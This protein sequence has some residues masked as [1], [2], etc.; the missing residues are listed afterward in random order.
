MLLNTTALQGG[1]LLQMISGVRMG[2]LHA[3]IKAQ[4]NIELYFS[5]LVVNYLLRGQLRVCFSRTNC[6]PRPKKDTMYMPKSSS[7]PSQTSPGYVTTFI[8]PS[9]SMKPTWKLSLQVPSSSS[10]S[11]APSTPTHWSRLPSSSC[12]GWSP[13]WCS[14]GSLIVDTSLLFDC[15]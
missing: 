3:N 5:N 1:N 15:R 11:K 7:L 14:G 13:S 12:S 10:T 2:I 9:S 4:P 6:R 8:R